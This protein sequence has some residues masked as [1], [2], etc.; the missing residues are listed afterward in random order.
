MI[1]IIFDELKKVGAVHSSAE[2]SRDWLGMEESY[3]RGIRARNRIP[4]AKAL[5]NC[6]LKLRTAGKSFSESQIP[7]VAERGHLMTQLGD[8]CIN[9]ILSQAMGS[10]G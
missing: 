1:E 2:F 5:A 3:L 9:E 6:A 8:A 10:Q 4:S 7:I